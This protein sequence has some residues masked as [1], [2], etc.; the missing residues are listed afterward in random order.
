[1]LL[2]E[3]KATHKRVLVTWTWYMVHYEEVSA[4]FTM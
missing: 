4:I 2:A 1:M 3:L